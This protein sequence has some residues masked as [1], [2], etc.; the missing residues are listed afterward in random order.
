[1][2]QHHEPP[3][4]VVT[5]GVAVEPSPPADPVL[6]DEGAIPMGTVPAGASMMITRRTIFFTITAGRCFGG[7]GA[8]IEDAGFGAAPR[9][10]IPVTKVAP[11]AT[12]AT[13]RTRP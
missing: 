13:A 3:V 9:M 6:E 5:G 4:E 1:V 10:P 11:P 12:Q 8:A 2:P 7:A